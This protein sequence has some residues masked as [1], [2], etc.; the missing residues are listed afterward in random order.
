MKNNNAFTSMVLIQ[1]ILLFVGLYM[2]DHFWW[3]S[4]VLLILLMFMVGLIGSKSFYK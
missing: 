2:I 4:A 1:A 3:Q